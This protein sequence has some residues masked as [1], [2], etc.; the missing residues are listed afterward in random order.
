M[1][2]YSRGTHIECQLGYHLLNKNVFTGLF[3]TFCSFC[4]P[5]SP[6]KD[7]VQYDQHIKQRRKDCGIALPLATWENLSSTFLQYSYHGNLCQIMLMLDGFTGQCKIIMSMVPSDKTVNCQVMAKRR[8]M[9]VKKYTW[10][11]FLPEARDGSAMIHWRTRK[12]MMIKCHYSYKTMGQGTKTLALHTHQ[13]RHS[14]PCTGQ[15]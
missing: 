3:V 11:G 12:T 6:F 15:Q 7:R 13:K 14:G 4:L 8:E 9:I 10:Q 5:S 1:N 2:L